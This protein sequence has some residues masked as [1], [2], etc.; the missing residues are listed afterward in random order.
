MMGVWQLFPFQ[1]RQWLE[2]CVLN[3]L[4]VL[5][6]FLSREILTKNLTIVKTWVNNETLSLI[7]RI[8]PNCQFVIFVYCKFTNTV[9]L[10]AVVVHSKIF[11]LFMKGKLDTYVLWPL[12][13]IIQNWI[14]DQPT[15]CNFTV[16]DSI[17]NSVSKW[18]SLYKW[19]L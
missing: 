4:S 19:P 5:S 17:L 15:A 8:L 16:W 14:V 7:D 3:F 11:K 2:F 12:A 1:R 10:G 9:R 18:M 6:D 13:K